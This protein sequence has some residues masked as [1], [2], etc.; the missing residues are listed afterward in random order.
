M[1]VLNRIWMEIMQIFGLEVHSIYLLQQLR[2]LEI[3]N[4]IW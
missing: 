2:F 1:Y 4:L 3:Q